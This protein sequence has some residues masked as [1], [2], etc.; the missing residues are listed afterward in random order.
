MKEIKIRY[1]KKKCIGAKKCLEIA[2]E[3]FAFADQKAILKGS[4]EGK[5]IHSLISKVNNKQL[6]LLKK[7]AL[8]CPVNALQIL[9][10]KSKAVL[11]SNKIKDS[12]KLISAKYD[13]KKEFILDKKGYFLIRI[14]RRNK[15]IE[16]AYCK[17]RNKIEYKVVGKKPLE[18]Y[19]TII[20]KGLISRMD[21][22]AY[23]GRELQKAY[24]AIREN[25]EY[26]QDNEL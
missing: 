24:I 22:A 25:K 15:N 19:Q 17:F 10:K 18:I 12:T 7:A 2:P 5:N 1:N 8:S 21:H 20:K 26:V 9:D 23:L 16:V 13:D 11:V 6:Q 14:N 4:K 3:Y